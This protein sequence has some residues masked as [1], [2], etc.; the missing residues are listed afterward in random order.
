MRRLLSSLLLSLVAVSPV[1]AAE[2][3]G[4]VADASGGVLTSATV[5]LLNVASGEQSVVVTDPSG[6]FRFAN[7]PVGIYRVAASFTGFS[8]SSRTVVLDSSAAAVTVDFG[9]EVGSVKTEV[10]VSADRGARDVQVVPLRADTLTG[11]TIREL[12]AVSTGDALLTAPGVTPVGSGPFQ[13]RPKLRGL[14]STRLLVLVDGERLNNARTATDR[15]GI[16]VGLVDPDSIE[17]LEVLGGAGSV[18]YGTDAL[19]GTINIITNRA[20]LTD[21]RQFSA[22]FDGFY[23]SNENGRRGTVSLGVSSNVF[24]VSF[25]GGQD[26]FGDYRAG[27]NFAETS[28]PFYD[29]GLLDQADTIDDAFGFRFNRFPDP[30]NAPFTRTSALIAN[31]GMTGASANLAAIGRLAANQTI[32]VKYQHRR[33][34]NVGFPDFTQP[35]FF[36]RISLGW[37]AFDKV[38]G[39]YTATN[40]R[41]WLSRVS[42]TAYFQTQDRL[43]RNDFP[44]QFPVPTAGSF[45]PISVFRLNIL[46]DTRQQVSTPGL[47]LQATFLAHP[48]NVLTA[49]ITVFQD[50]S[51]DDRVTTT[52]T[53]QIGRV[54]LGQSG[55]AATVFAAPLVLG[56]PVVE[57]PVR[58]PNARFRDIG[59]FAHNEWTATTDLRLTAGLRVDGYR[60]T[61]EATPGYEIEDLVTGASPAIDR[62]T[63]PNVN[64]AEIGR[65]AFT[66]EAGLVYRPDHPVSVFAH[67]VRSYR[68][69]NLEELLF[70]GPATTGNIVPNVTV[71]P[72]TG[73]NVDVGTR[74]RFPKFIGSLSYFNNTYRDFISTEVVALLPD[75][76]SVSQAINLARVRIQGIEA[77]GNAPFFAGA[78]TWLPYANVSYNRGTVLDGATPLTGV[79]LTGEPQDNITPWKISAGVRVGDRQ[80]RW[81][82]AYGVRAQTEVSRVSPLLEDSPFLIAQDL[83]GLEGFSIHR[84]AAGYDWRKGGQRVGL[85]LSVDNLTDVFYREHFQFAPARGRSVS[86]S[87]RIR[88]IR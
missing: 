23:S 2:L 3:D 71:K 73:H 39:T 35:Y 77:E 67:Y 38:S 75:S 36:Q 81:W 78:L 76:D 5:T 59:I 63:L 54:A 4:R 83:F 12:A 53:T 28:Q 57:K 69:A 72:E 56:D 45:F 84:L 14:D 34:E 41:P 74:L 43:L 64:G 82:A 15:A 25:T 62:G 31:S 68:H 18:L 10:T 30:F 8:E 48:K 55:P 9:L 42:A 66:G 29:S 16:E 40:L 87:L 52:Q 1:L 86:L 22:G 61:T 19:S 13:I 50:R 49:G 33:A 58:V 88:G 32:E 26:R 65:T 27:K 79:A 70:S 80:E 17:V 60:V 11:D 20:R 24:S 21:T 7:L 37:S 51:E 46:S 85:T 44:V 47:D 6:R